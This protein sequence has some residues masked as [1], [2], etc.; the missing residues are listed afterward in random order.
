[1]LDLLKAFD[2]VNHKI[3]ISKLENYGVRENSLKLIND[4]L[5]NRKQVFHVNNTYSDQQSIV[6]GV[7]QGSTLGPLLLSI[8]V[9]DQPKAS[10]FETQLFAEDTALFP[11]DEHLKTL[12][13]DVNYELHNIEAWLN[14][15][16]LSLNYSKTKYLLIKPKTKFLNCANLL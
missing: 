12:N 2:T 11:F 15:N 9:N 1:M 7:P 16:K 10:K 8:Y 13:K 6:C 4:Y 3:L 14:V 5:T